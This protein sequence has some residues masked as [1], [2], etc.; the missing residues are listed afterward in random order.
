MK[1]R[2][3]REVISYWK[4][5]VDWV[6]GPAPAETLVPK[7]RC[8][9]SD[10]TLESIIIKALILILDFIPVSVQVGF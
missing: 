1:K 5:N 9:S 8:L 7:A 2:S 3:P 10:I 4:V 6:V